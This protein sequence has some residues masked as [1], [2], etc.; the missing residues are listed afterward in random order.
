MTT[1]EL[2]QRIK[3]TTFVDV[4]GLESYVGCKLTDET[5]KEASQYKLVGSLLCNPIFICYL[6]TL[7]GEIF[8]TTAFGE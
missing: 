3:G 6:L 2:M 1:K 5:N 8:I 4:K 7:Q